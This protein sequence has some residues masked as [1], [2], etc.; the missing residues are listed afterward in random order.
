MTM[1]T[2][3]YYFFK[4]MKCHTFSEL[5]VQA[6][7]ND[8]NGEDYSDNNIK[9]NN[10]YSEVLFSSKVIHFLESKTQTNL[11]DN[12]G[13][14]DYKRD[15]YDKYHNNNNK[16]LFYSKVSII[17]HGGYD[18]NHNDR[19]DMNNNMTTKYDFFQ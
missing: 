3:K 13:K 18:N 5:Q 9:D 8:A 17:M 12:A 19:D 15:N 11:N 1:M 4:S 6:Y 7:L 14:D 10:T 2:T 16:I